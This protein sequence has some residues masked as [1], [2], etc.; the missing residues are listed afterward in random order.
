M[1][2]L[3]WGLIPSWATD[4]AIGNRLIN[5]RSETV[6]LKPAFRAAF[7][8]RR[9]LIPV[10][11]F[12]E[13]Q[14]QDHWKKP[15]YI[16]NKDGSPMALAGLWEHWTDI[17][18]ATI[19][20]CTILT[21]HANALVEELHTRMP[22]LIKPQDFDTWLDSSLQDLTTLQPLLQPVPSAALAM[23]PVSRFV[24]KPENEGPECIEEVKE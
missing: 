12:F 10:S 2:L 16:Y 24:N 6:A 19:E 8:K 15:Y 9:C 22:V 18:G 17:K 14:S 1:A 5:A 20:T 7:R 21:T 3:R 11:G 13:W 4:P 23:H